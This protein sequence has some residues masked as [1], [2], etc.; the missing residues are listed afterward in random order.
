MANLRQRIEILE[1]ASRIVES[2][3]AGIFTD[4]EF[5]VQFEWY[6]GKLPYVTMNSLR[7]LEDEIR[8]GR[9]GEKEDLSTI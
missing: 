8:E 4:A 1:V 6:L 7:D 5:H 9:Q 2:R 3:K